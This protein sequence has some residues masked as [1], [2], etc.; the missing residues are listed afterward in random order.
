MIKLFS[1]SLLPLPSPE[2]A[3]EEAVSQLP[4]ARLKNPAQMLILY[5]FTFVGHLHLMIHR[6]RFIPASAYTHCLINLLKNVR[7]L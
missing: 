6:L 2:E 3:Q 7:S 1:L 4:V 5:K